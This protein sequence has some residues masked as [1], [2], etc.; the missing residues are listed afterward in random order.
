M[1]ELGNFIFILK[2]AKSDAA[3]LS[4]TFLLTVFVDL[5]VAIEIGMVLAAF[6]FMRR[7]M[8]ISSVQQLVSSGEAGEPDPLV[9][10][11]LPDEVAVFEISG[12]L[13][14]GA[15][16][17]FKDAMQEIGQPPKVLIIRM[18]HVPVI[19]ATGLRVLKEVHQQLQAKGAKLIL[20]EI[21]NE[22]VMAE[23]Q[24]ARLLFRIGKGNVRNTFEMAVQ[25]AKELL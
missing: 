24:K 13:F 10:Y 4:A 5:T 17:K 14:F 15:A 19:D 23:L 8:K 18:Q 20:S 9:A 25:R 11:A 16:Y 6:L 1:S 3:V 12:P 2:G 7:M 21:A 22:P